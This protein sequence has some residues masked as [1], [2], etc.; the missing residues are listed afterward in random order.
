MSITFQA[1]RVLR[2]LADQPHQSIPQTQIP[3]EV[4]QPDQVRGVYDELVNAD[5]INPNTQDISGAYS[6]YLTTGGRVMADSI[7][8]KYRPSLAQRRVLEWLHNQQSAAPSGLLET[9]LANDF[10]GTLTEAEVKQAA[11]ELKDGGFIIATESFGGGMTRAELTS[12][13]N[14]LY[15]NGMSIE[16]SQP[17]G[18]VTTNI[19]ANNYGQQT[20]GNQ[21]VGSQ[22]GTMHSQTSTGFGGEE[23]VRELEALRATVKSAQ[24]SEQEQKDLLEQ[25][26]L[27][28][29]QM[30]RQGPNWVRDILHAL[31]ASAAKILGEQAVSGLLDLL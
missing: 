1:E 26:S 8:R 19:T 2:W 9:P 4:L 29:R 6:F 15:R 24:I 5:F 17:S 16:Q 13:G 10:D 7:K 25:I 11:Q 21:A 30:D 28:K 31:A 23:I 27:I 3:E 12:S 14:N 22:V 20:I 18:Q